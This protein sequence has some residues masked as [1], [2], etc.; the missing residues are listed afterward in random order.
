MLRI[1]A[2]AADVK[3]ME[4]KKHTAALMAALVAFA[5]LALAA[6]TVAAHTCSSYEGCDAQ[7]C[8]DGEDHKHTDKNW[9]AD[10]E[11]C[12]SSARTTDPESC[13]YNGIEFPAIVCRLIED[14]DGG[15]LGCIETRWTLPGG[16][17]FGDVCAPVVA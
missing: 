3:H 5:G 15:L 16:K 11:Y 6:P 17:G 4:S 2:P 1:A 9:V 7:N 13:E 14:D 10:D 8:P 12:E